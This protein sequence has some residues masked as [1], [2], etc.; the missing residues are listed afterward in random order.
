MSIAQPANMANISPGSHGQGIDDPPWYSGLG[1]LFNA[2]DNSADKL[3][4]MEAVQQSKWFDSGYPIKARI[5]ANL[6]V[7]FAA[8]SHFSVFMNHPDFCK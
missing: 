3:P 1:F 7:L 5:M 4:A 8:L 6:C 2:P